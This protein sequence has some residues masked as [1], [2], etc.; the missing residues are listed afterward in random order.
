MHWLEAESELKVDLSLEQSSFMGKYR[1]FYRPKINI[2]KL[3][4]EVDLNDYAI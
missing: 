1:Q 2:R 3:I 4:P